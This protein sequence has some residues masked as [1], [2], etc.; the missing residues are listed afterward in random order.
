MAEPFP[1]KSLLFTY[2]TRRNLKE[3]PSVSASFR[4]ADAATGNSAVDNKVQ[5]CKE[6]IQ[7][8]SLCW[9]TK[10]LWCSH[11]S[12]GCYKLD[13]VS[14]QTGRNSKRSLLALLQ[15]ARVIAVH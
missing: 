6:W 8:T 3:P 12:A 15:H 14:V 1:E 9:E 11:V 7:I 4:S 5:S 2:F 10:V 13:Y